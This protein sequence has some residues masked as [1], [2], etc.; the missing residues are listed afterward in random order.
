MSAVQTPVRARSTLAT[1]RPASELGANKPHGDRLRYMAGCRCTECRRANTQYAIA[2]EAA[3]KAGDWN[4]F[5]SADRA[6]AHLEVLSAA[7]IGRRQVADA[8][9]VAQVIVAAIRRGERTKIRARTE[10][11]ILSVTPAAAAD[12]ARIDAAPTWKLIDDLLATGYTKKRIALELGYT[13]PA[14]Q[15]RKDKVLARNAYAVQRLHERLRRVPAAPALKLVADL[16]EEGYSPYRIEALVAQ[17]A[18]R[19]GRPVP[20]MQVHGEFISSHAADLLQRLHAEQ[21]AE[22][23]A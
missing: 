23:P 9:G 20:D 16:R 7:D 22:E 17:L 4:G 11:A 10:R 13:T 3:R 15:F 21:L 6:R 19:L 8:A 14:I 1:L 18:A 5:V 2:R 12:C